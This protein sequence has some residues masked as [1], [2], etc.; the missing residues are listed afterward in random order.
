MDFEKNINEK[1]LEDIK[2]EVIENVEEVSEEYNNEEEM[3]KLE[4]ADIKKTGGLL[5]K[6]RELIKKMRPEKGVETSIEELPDV[7]KEEIDKLKKTYN[8]ANDLGRIMIDSLQKFK[9]EDSNID[10]YEIRAHIDKHG[11]GA[12]GYVGRDNVVFEARVEDE[13]LLGFEMKSSK[14]RSK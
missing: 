3:V 2:E 4:E 7:V 13:S 8:M 12:T 9:D 1:K 14:F 5:E 11:D 10:K 6:A